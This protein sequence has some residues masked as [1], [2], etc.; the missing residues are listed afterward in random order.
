MSIDLHIRWSDRQDLILRR[1]VL[2]DRK[3]LKE[4]GVGKMNRVD[5]KAKLEPPAP[6][7]FHCSLSDYIPHT[8]NT[9]NNEPQMT[10]STGFDRLRESGLQKKDIRNIRTQIS[11][12]LEEQW[13]DNTGETLPDGSKLS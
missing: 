7:Y 4:Y 8:P 10:P 5:S 13:M 1:R 2:E 12:N 9:Q 3:T 6:V 11:S